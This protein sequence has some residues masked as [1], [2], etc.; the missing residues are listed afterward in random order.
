MSAVA[1]AFDLLTDAIDAMY[2]GIDP[3]MLDALY[4]KLERYGL[5]YRR[6]TADDLR[7]LFSLCGI[8]HTPFRTKKSLHDQALESGG[9][10]SWLERLGDVELMH[11]AARKAATKREREAEETTKARAGE[12]AL[13]PESVR[14]FIRNAPSECVAFG[15]LLSRA[16][17]SGDVSSAPALKDAYASIQERMCAAPD[18]GQWMY[19]TMTDNLDA[20]AVGAELGDDMKAALG[21]DIAE[22][23]SDAVDLHSV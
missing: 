3:R 23:L 8:D 18:Q 16:V 9:T 13:G 19:D 17:A 15:V 11:V 4:H 10:D 12:V 5:D 2:A 22:L 1:A 6:W 20:A 14:D 21:E 7:R